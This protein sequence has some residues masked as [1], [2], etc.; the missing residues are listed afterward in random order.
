MLKDCLEIAVGKDVLLKIYSSKGDD[1]FDEEDAVDNGEARYQLVEGRQYEYGFDGGCQFAE[2]SK[3]VTFSKSHHGGGHINTGNYVGELALQCV[4]PKDGAVI[5]TVRLEIRSCK[6]SYREDYRSMMEDITSYYTDLV[7]QQGS[8]VTQQLEADAESSPQTLYQRFAFVNAIVMSSGFADAVHQVMENPVRRWAET[9]SEHDIAHVRRLGRGGVRQILTATDRVPFEDG[10]L[11]GLPAG[12]ASLPRKV[13]MPDKCD[14]ID[15]AENQFVKYVLYAFSSFCSELSSLK[16]ATERLRKEA[17]LVCDRL[18]DYLNTIFFK[19]VSLPTHLN[20]NSPVLQRK[21][22]YREVLQAWLIFDLAAK[23]TWKGGDNVYEAG[24]RNVAALYEYWVF[25]KL[26]AVVSDI[27]HLDKGETSH[28][29]DYG[30]DRIDL[31]IRQGK[32]TMLKGVYDAGSRRLNVRF[33]YNRTFSYTGQ[34]EH[35]SYLKPGSWTMTM[36]PD[37]TLSIWPGDDDMLQ[38]ERE[39]RIVH[40]HFDA[41]YKVSQFELPQADRELGD[42]EDVSDEVSQS[43]LEEKEDEEKGIYR[44]GDLL[45]MHAYKDAIRRTSGAYIIYPGTESQY[46]NGFHEIIPGLGAFCLTPNKEDGQIE[47]LKGFILKVVEHM[48]NRTSDREKMS[49]YQY[50]LYDDAERN[51]DKVC[52]ELPEPFGKNRS[53]LPSET[54]VLVGYCKDD[55]QLEWISK[56]NLYNVRTG[57]GL[58]GVRLNGPIVS[59]QYLLLHREGRSIKLLKLSQ[60]GPRIVSRAELTKKGYPSKKRARRTRRTHDYYLLY[61]VAMAEEEFAAYSWKIS[62]LTDAIGS[63]QAKPFVIRLS[64]LMNKVEK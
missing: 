44:R 35:N 10:P 41:K 26:F 25:F 50:K 32:M 38:A 59:A 12:L 11:Y 64:E 34:D 21:E 14:T 13:T 7:L 37:Y 47:E 52:E 27:F 4:R 15:T 23:L 51:R 56:E 31:H 1:L 58:G 49:Y 43:L 19:Q 16:G 36:R 3:I 53:F 60:G 62:K 57:T 28:L 39:E 30:K 63:Q 61:D 8:P 45:K 5:G 40:I 33:Y 9:V 42:G 55:D 29:V 2:E 20:L 46:R 6:M 48:L 24:K 17:D 18:D 54:W 22:G